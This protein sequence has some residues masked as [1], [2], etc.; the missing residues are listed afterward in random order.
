MTIWSYRRLAALASL[1]VA[2]CIPSALPSAPMAN[3]KP[4]VTPSPAPLANATPASLHEEIFSPLAA[5]PAP[6]D[7][8]LNVYASTMATAVPVELAG[9]KPRVYVPD[10]LSNT[11]EVIDPET[12]KV[13]DRFATGSIPHHVAPAPDLSTLYVDNEGSST[14]TQIDVHTGRPVRNIPVTYPYNLYFTLDGSKAVVVAERL[15]RLEFWDAHDWKQLKIVDIP[16]PGADHLDFSADG[17]YLFVSTE[18]SGMLAR[19]NVETMQL[20]GSVSVGGLPVDVR[21]SPD[22]TVLYVANQGRQG[23]SV[24]DPQQMKEVAFI[25]TGQGAHGLQVSRDTTKLYVTNRLAGTISVIDFE[26]RAVV[27]TWK[28]GG[29]PDMTQLSPDGKQ[30]WVSSRFDAGVMVVDT[31]D[32]HL[33]A[34]IPTGPGAHGLTYFPNVGSRSIGHNGVYR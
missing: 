28:I 20:E 13:V 19:V 2:A 12:M 32:G 6:A 27:A 22:G 11:V 5:G 34:R 26:K 24:V 4:E 25:P 16:W 7:Q 3:A 31:G 8:P 23:V 1:L 21:L 29:S 33:I 10:S 14:L 9:I 17:K 30:L 18:Y 15:R